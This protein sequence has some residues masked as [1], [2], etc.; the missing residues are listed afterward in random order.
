MKFYDLIWLIPVLPLLGAIFNGFVSNRLGLSKSVTHTVALLGSGLA[1]LLGW[2]AIVQWI[3]DLG[4]HHTHIVRLFSWIQGGS[5]RI[6]DGS[7]AE[8]NIAASFQLDAVSALMVSFVTFVGF[9]IHVYSIGYM[10]DE[11]DRA[12]ARYFSYLNLFMFS[13]LVL[14]LGSN[15]AVLFVGWEGVGLC[16]YLLIGFYFEKDWCA[17]AGMKAFI[18]NRI[19]DWGF[20][21]AIF[22]T[23]MV[24]G[25]LEFT[26]FFPA[27]AAHPEHFASA[28]TVIGLLLFV[29]AI[30]KS[31]QIPLYVWLPDAMAGPTPVSALIHA[32]TMVTAGVYMVVRCNVIYRLSP[33]AMLVVAIVGGLTAIFA[34]T[35]GLVQ[36]DIK[37][38]LAYSTVSQL[39]YM[40]LGAGVG[41]FVA[42]IFHV[43]THAFFKACL[44]LGS[45]SVIHACGGE[46][47][48]RKMGGLKKYMPTTYWTF[49]VATLA[50]SGIPIFAGFFSKDEILFKAFE[51]GASDLNRFGSA[52]YVL[53]VLGMVGAVLTAFYM[54][55]LVFMTFHGE[56]R[57]GEEAEH[58]LHESPWTMT[59]PLVVLGVLS[60][61]GGFL[62]IPGKLFHHPEWNL[63]E[64]FLEPML[65]PIGHAAEAGH[66]V[67]HHAVSLGL[68]WGLVV[69]SVAVA[70]F[71]IWLAYRFYMGA[72]ALVRPQRLAERFPL[73]HKLL[74]N[75]YW[76]DEIYDATVI[77]GTV[78][79]SRLLW[80]FDARVVDGAVN[81]TALTTVGSSFMSGIFDLRVVDGAVNLIATC[82]DVASRWFRKLQVGFAQGYAMVMVFGAAILL[83]VYYLFKLN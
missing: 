70:S 67:S 40:F 28:A 14:V 26:E 35:I 24:F 58:H 78:K 47:D 69:L 63:V 51:A 10:H 8:V 9:L 55:R 43:L 23:F 72:E 21:L 15:L 3:L 50:I 54:F 80:E 39:G 56:F 49:L 30:G 16:S 18:V 68:E 62:G 77:S 1:W 37:K 48:I 31:A 5:L 66:D 20:L 7:L 73:A 52:Y 79:G 64:R 11:S 34:A 19:G 36:N 82:Y 57:G 33:T 59:M 71:G 25:T 61:F 83:A 13:M 42:A 22:A 74:L 81:G 38:V 46:Q 60:I 65:L 17:A 2:G 12:Y 32:A 4:I 44:F 6:L 53:W 29:G 75:K 76:M 27:A 45:G 41:A